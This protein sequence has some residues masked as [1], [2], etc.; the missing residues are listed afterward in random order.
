MLV[1]RI[2]PDF[3]SRLF[4]VRRTY[5]KMKEQRG[6]SILDK[7]VSKTTKRSLFR[8]KV[9]FQTQSWDKQKNVLS[10]PGSN[11]ECVLNQKTV[12]GPHPKQSLPVSRTS[13]RKEK[14]EPEMV[15]R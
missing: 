10:T 13:I 5:N 8:R 14:R 2:E 6:R 9:R 1:I 3:Q 11:P 15:I 12:Q 7:G 4:P